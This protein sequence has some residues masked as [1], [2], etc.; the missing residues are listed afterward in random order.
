MSSKPTAKASVAA[1]KPLR[2]SSA[3]PESVLK[4][5]KTV[6]ALKSQTVKSRTLRAK[7]GATIRKTI[8]KR[9]EKYVKE[10]RQSASSLVRFKRQ[11][12]NAGN[13]FI[14][15][16]AKVV[17]VV[18]IRGINAIS[19]QPKKILQLLRLRQVHNGVF[20]RLNKA[21]LTMLRLVEN[22]ITYGP[23]TLKSISD[24]IYKRG[25]GKV[26]KQRIPLTNNKIISDTLGKHGII[27]VEDLIHEIYTC[28]PNF[29][30][31]ANFLWPF[32]LSSPNGG[33]VEKATHFT[34]GGDYGNREEE[35]NKFIK[36]MV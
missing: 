33:Y 15:P 16:E 17:F 5:R 23:P 27:C 36:R 13:F 8:F 28:G 25:Y 10:Y 7:K 12:K 30:H 18:R 20:V 24:L 3:A 21:T 26:D 11:A 34:E 1:K 4:K 22:Y 29:K 19:P 31:A 14:E 35:I 9:A 2:L 32:K 6:S